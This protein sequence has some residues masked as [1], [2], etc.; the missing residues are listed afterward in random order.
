MFCGHSSV[1][2]RLVANEKVEGSS[3]F[4]RSIFKMFENIKQKY[5]KNNFKNN[6]EKKT[7]FVKQSRVTV[8]EYTYGYK[9]LNIIEYGFGSDLYIGKFT[10]I[11]PG[12]KIFLDYG[13][14]NLDKVSLYPFGELYNEIFNGRLDDLNNRRNKG[15]VIIGNDVWIGLDVLILNGLTIGDGAVIGANSVVTKN[16]KPYEFVSGNPAKHIRFRFEK[17][18]ID[19]L[20]QIKWWDLEEKTI[21]KILPILQTKPDKKKFIETFNEIKDEIKNIL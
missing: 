3:P 19:L 17:E 2:E 18:I 5:F 10:S 7:F 11:S 16:V 12:V 4:A 20:M 14:H 21:N 1:V 6:Q 15:N 9:N 8:G 13:G